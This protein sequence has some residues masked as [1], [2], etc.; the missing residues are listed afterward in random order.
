ML[1]HCVLQESNL[2]T[3]DFDFNFARMIDENTIISIGNIE[4]NRLVR[5]VARGTSIYQ[6]KVS[7]LQV[8]IKL[9]RI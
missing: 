1:N 4:R 9:R 6:V 5:L 2:V 8:I 3:A 7:K